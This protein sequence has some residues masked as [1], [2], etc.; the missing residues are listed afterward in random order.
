MAKINGNKKLRVASLFCGCGGMD[1]G[2]QE[3][4][5]VFRLQAQYCGPIWLFGASIEERAAPTNAGSPAFA[6]FQEYQDE[7]PQASELKSRTLRIR[8]AL[9]QTD[10]ILIMEKFNDA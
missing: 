6:S 2:I 9:S 10:K 3:M 5:R 4:G 7:H 1:L 8:R